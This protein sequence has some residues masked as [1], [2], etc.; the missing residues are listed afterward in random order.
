RS[1]VDTLLAHGAD[2]NRR[3]R[4]ARSPL[5]SASAHDDP[6][7]VRTLLDHGAD[8]ASKEAALGEAASSGHARIVETLLAAGAHVEARDP[9]GRTPLLAA[10]R[11]DR[12]A[13]VNVLLAHG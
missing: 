10:V 3:T 2:V 9:S 1:L 7:L 13:A 8:A 11:A 6:D 4:Y 12:V 5:E